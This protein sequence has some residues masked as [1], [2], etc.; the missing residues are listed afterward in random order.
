MKIIILY[1]CTNKTNGDFYIGITGKTLSLRM[2]DHFSNAKKRMSCRKFHAALN[3]YGK[4]NFSWKIINEFSNYEDALKSEEKII[5]DLKPSYNISP[6]GRA[7]VI[8]LPRTEE[9]KRKISEANKGRKPS[10][11]AVEGARKAIA[12]GLFDRQV[13]CLNDGKIFKRVKDAATF[14]N[15]NAG[16]VTSIC[17]DRAVSAKGFHFRYYERE[18]SKSKRIILMKK[19]HERINKQKYSGGQARRT[20]VKCLNDNKEYKSIVLASK[21]YGI[22]QSTITQLCQRKIIATRDKNLTFRYMEKEA[23]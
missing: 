6:G 15:V 19:G 9:W 7:G 10:A 16:Q 13:I 21:Y 20:S 3:K 18:I 5:S 1:K 23:A 2:S 14:Y 4:E 12:N 17:R 8:G 22:S 11:S